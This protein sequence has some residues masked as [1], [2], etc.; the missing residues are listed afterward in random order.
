ME[1]KYMYLSSDGTKKDVRNLDYQYLVNAVAKAHRNVIESNTLEDYKKN[2][3]NIEILEDE[4]FDRR[5]SH[6]LELN[7]EGE[8]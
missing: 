6:F 7:N 1:E 2:A 8:K 4:L 3:K 5:N